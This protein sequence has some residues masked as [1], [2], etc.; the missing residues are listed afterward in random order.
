LFHLNQI[1]LPLVCGN[2]S[3][4]R[5][6]GHSTRP[7]HWA[8]LTGS[9]CCSHEGWHSQWGHLPT[10][11]S[12]GVASTDDPFNSPCVLD[13]GRMKANKVSDTHDDQILEWTY[14]GFSICSSSA[15]DK[16]PAIVS[17]NSQKFASSLVVKWC[18]TKKPIVVEWRPGKMRGPGP[19]LRCWVNLN[20]DCLTLINPL[21]T[22]HPIIVTSTKWLNKLAI[23]G[24]LEETNTT[25]KTHLL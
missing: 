11:T 10:I 3:T 4:I 18:T 23:Q 25:Y 13:I 17:G 15:S 22:L 19:P 5:L 1:C 21:R 6:D 8:T 12:C 9:H 14:P 7:R 16:H 20:R 24:P 2:W